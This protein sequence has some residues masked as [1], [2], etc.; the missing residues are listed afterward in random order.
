MRFVFV[1]LVFAFMVMVPLSIAAK[2]TPNCSDLGVLEGSV[3]ASQIMDFDVTK[4]SHGDMVAVY[5]YSDAGGNESE[6]MSISFAKMD[7]GGKWSYEPVQA[8]LSFSSTTSITFMEDS[9]GVYWVAYATRQDLGRVGVGERRNT[10]IWLHTSRDGGATWSSPIRVVS[11]TSLHESNIGIWD[12]CLV[13]D[14]LGG[15]WLVWNHVYRRQRDTLY[16]KSDDRGATWIST[17]SFGL[18]KNRYEAFFSDHQGDLHLVYMTS[19][20]LERGTLGQVVSLD[21]D[22]NVRWSSEPMRLAGIEELTSEVF[23]AELYSEVCHNSTKVW[24]AWMDNWLKGSG[25]EWDSGEQDIMVLASSPDAGLN[26]EPYGYF[27][28]PNFKTGDQ[29]IAIP[30][31]SDD[32]SGDKLCLLWLSRTGELLCKSIP[33]PIPISLAIL[34][35]LAGIHLNRTA[36]R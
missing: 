27:T 30:Q 20:Y 10:S 19:V 12:L 17:R 1:V 16:T 24:I 6:G 23:F 3:I 36:R 4:N 29:Y 14:D 11:Y 35:F 26:W 31:S 15:V 5:S 21:Y 32:Q 8:P 9:E 34:T 2:F 22:K 33:D 7:S 18:G 13:E 25:E 28:V